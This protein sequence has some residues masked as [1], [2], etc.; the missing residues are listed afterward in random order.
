LGYSLQVNAYLEALDKKLVEYVSECLTQEDPKKYWDATRD[1][2]VVNERGIQALALKPGEEALLNTWDKFIQNLRRNNV[3]IPGF[4]IW[5][6]FWKQKK[7]IP[8]D[9]PPWKRNFIEKNHNFFMNNHK[10]CSQLLADLDS[11]DFI[12][13]HRKLEWQA[14]DLP[15]VWDGVVHLRPSGVRVKKANYFPALVAITHVP[16]LA[17]KKRRLSVKEAAFLQGFPR[18][19]DF[20]Q[21]GEAQS[22]KQLGNAVNVSAVWVAIRSLVQRDREILEMTPQGRKL[23]S[24]VNSAS[25]SPDDF[26][27]DW[28][29]EGSS[30]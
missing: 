28:F 4:P 24:L 13:S 18:N 16:I 2:E 22:Y 20:S 7:R 29:P 26:F 10:A 14:G 5:T 11:H 8:K 9:C 21:S 27:R 6:E 12:K 30:S 19:F 23:V 25:D 17:F 1:L 15:S 3:E